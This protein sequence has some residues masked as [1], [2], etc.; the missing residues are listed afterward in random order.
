MS[1][2][3]DSIG[4]V[5]AFGWGSPSIFNSSYITI[6]TV[7]LTTTSSVLIEF[8]N[9]PQTYKHLEVRAFV[10][11]EGGNVAGGIPIAFNAST[12]TDYVSSNL[13][14]GGATYDSI[15][16]GVEGPTNPNNAAFGIAP[17]ANN[18][19]NAFG[20]N[21]YRIA[22]YTNSNKNMIGHYY[23]AGLDNTNVSYSTINGALYRQSQG[24]MTSFIFHAPQGTSGW[25]R[26][27]HVALYGIK[28]SV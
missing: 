17:Q 12:S 6:A 28:D 5:K 20:A 26:Y 4:S 7:N 21:V 8:N 15:R 13:F 2:I 27:S 25:A 24:A 19:A 1:P 10:R 9:I 16:E 23:G 3:L 22:D 14:V 11:T 18:T